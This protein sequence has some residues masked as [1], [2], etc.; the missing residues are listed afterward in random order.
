[1]QK[2]TYGTA[3]SIL[4]YQYSFNVEADADTEIA[5]KKE[6]ENRFSTAVDNGVYLHGYSCRSL[7]EQRSSFYALYG[8]L[9]FLGILLSIVFL[10]GTVL[11]MYYKQISEG[12]ED[13]A[14][15]EIMQKVGMTK[16]EIKK[17]INSQI[18]TVFA[19]PL[20]AAGVHTAFAF[21][22]VRRLLILFG[23]TNIPLLIGITIVSFLIFAVLYALMYKLTSH[24][25][26][27]LVK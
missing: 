11:I 13:A 24:S 19:A 6:I 23:L 1:M 26:Y 20:L 7:E 21:P 25:Y 18:L 8:G 14:R 10:F 12:Y 9:L 5:V 3:A 15:F 4:E 17:S 27:Q 16:Q 2:E 22:L